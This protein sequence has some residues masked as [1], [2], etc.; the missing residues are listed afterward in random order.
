[1]SVGVGFFSIAGE[2]ERVTRQLNI[3]GKVTMQIYQIGGDPTQIGKSFEKDQSG[4]Y[5]FM[6]CSFTDM[7]S[8]QKYINSLV[9]YAT[10]KF[11][12]QINVKTG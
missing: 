4:T 1:M 6:K 5:Y 2:I 9:D 3:T 10:N 7:S 8:C 11:P 12:T